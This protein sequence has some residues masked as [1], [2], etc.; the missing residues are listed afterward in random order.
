[1]PEIPTIETI[2][3]VIATTGVDANPL[4]IV[5]AEIGNLVEVD[6]S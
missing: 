4:A 1:M 3:A 5:G 2:S 6:R